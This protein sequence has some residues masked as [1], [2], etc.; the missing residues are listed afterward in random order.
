MLARPIVKSADA[1]TPAEAKKLCAHI[2]KPQAELLSFQAP[3]HLEAL[4]EEIEQI[5]QRLGPLDG[6]EPDTIPLE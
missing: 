2:P 3:F 5:R 4:D 6:R 1:L